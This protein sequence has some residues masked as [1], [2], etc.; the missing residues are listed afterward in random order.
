MSNFYPATTLIGGAAGAL[1]AI[2]GADLS[3]SDG[4]IVITSTRTYAYQLNAVSGAAESSPWVISPDVNAGTKRWIFQTPWGSSGWG[5]QIAV[6]I[7]AA[8]ILILP[9]PG[10]YLV[11]PEA[12]ATDTLTQITGLVDGDEILMNRESTKE[13]IIQDSA[14]IFLVNSIN[15]TMNHDNDNIRLICKGGN[16]MEETGRVSNG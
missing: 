1:D 10:R 3:D 7:G 11:S 13:I 6:T 14:N 15:F 5:A 12:G 8:G 9:G 16:I 4:A 2:D